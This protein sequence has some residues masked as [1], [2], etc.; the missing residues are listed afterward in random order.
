MAGKKGGDKPDKP[1][2]QAPV[3]PSHCPAKE[4][5]QNEWRFGFCKEHYDHYKFGLI[6]KKGERV[7][8]YDKKKK[9]FEAYKERGKS[10]H[11]A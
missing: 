3:G 6:N 10:A 2:R 7:S 5:K 8:D 9:H 1:Q 4:C 11:V